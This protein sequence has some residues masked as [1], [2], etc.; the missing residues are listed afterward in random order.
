MLVMM[1]KFFGEDASS[2]DGHVFLVIWESF[3]CCLTL[4]LVNL[5]FVFPEGSE[6]R[7]CNLKIWDV[8][9][10]QQ[11]AELKGHTH[12]VHSVAFDRSGKYLASGEVTYE[13]MIMMIMMIMQWSR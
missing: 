9:T 2:F 8:S 1:K 10:W 12:K 3:L 11:V 13:M 5:L 6:D 4:L 7:G